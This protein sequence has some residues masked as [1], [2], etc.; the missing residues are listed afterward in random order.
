M[1]HPAI[2][3]VEGGRNGAGILPAP[4]QPTSLIRDGRCKFKF[5]TGGKP[6]MAKK[7]L[8]LP[9]T[10]FFEGA[11]EVHVHRCPRAIQDE[12]DAV[13]PEK[14]G[15]F[16][17]AI[18][19]TT[20]QHAAM[21]LVRVG[22]VVDVEKD[23]LLERVR[24]GTRAQGA[25]WGG[26]GRAQWWWWWWWGTV[27]CWRLCVVACVKLYGGGVWGCGSPHRACSLGACQPLFCH[28]VARPACGWE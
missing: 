14:R 15:G 9:R 12:L 27:G 3:A 13:F 22:L 18:L 6:A 16:K 8:L 7:T 17:E 24:T 2:V 25:G 4:L 20:A 26:A 19:I 1:Q 10:T 21:D 11:M 5:R 28:P 23:K